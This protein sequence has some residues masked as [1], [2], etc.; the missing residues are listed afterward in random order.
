MLNL[1]QCTGLEDKWSS[2]CFRGFVDQTVDTKKLRMFVATFKEGSMRQASRSLFVTPSALSHGIRALEESL[3]VSLFERK[4]PVLE[5]TVAGKRFFVEA[6][7][8]LSRLDS[9]VARFSGGQ[10]QENLQL[11]I[12]TTNTGCSQFFPAIVR[13]FRES[14]PD[15]ALKLEIGDT[16]YLLGRLEEAKL[17][18]VIAPIQRDYKLLTQKVLGRDELV[19]LVHPTHQW[20]REGGVDVGSLENQRLIMPSMQSQTYSLIDSCY[21]EMRVALEPFIELNNE[22]AIRQLVSLN[23]GTGIL[24]RWIAQDSIERQVLHAFQLGSAPLYRRWTV[25]YRSSSKLS[26]PEFLFIEMT[27]AVARKLLD[28]LAS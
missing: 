15:V 9:A 7:D 19:Y 11:H 3:Q 17:D 16:N 23:I 10:M 20:V 28:R 1:I 18:F 13:E 2:L 21:R 27:Q 24:P 4:G 8:I 25:A 5:P 14:F 6:S 26:F 12:G 22:E